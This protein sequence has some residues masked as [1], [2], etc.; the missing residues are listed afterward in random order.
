MT[1]MPS[2][3]Y[4]LRHDISVE[5]MMLLQGVTGQVDHHEVNISGLSNIA[6]DK[7]HDAIYLIDS[8]LRIK[9]VNEKSLPV[10]GIFP[11]GIFATQL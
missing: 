10:D 6:L 11:R 2:G 9:Y 4:S 1:V 5:G 3:R 7:I 8:Q